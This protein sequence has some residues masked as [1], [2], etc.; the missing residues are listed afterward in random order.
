RA[1]NQQRCWSSG[2]RLAYIFWFA[3]ADPA[4]GWG[5]EVRTRPSHAGRVGR[6]SDHRTGDMELALGPAPLDEVA[7]SCSAGH[8]D[9]ARNTGWTDGL[10][11]PAVVDLNRPC[12]ARTK[13]LLPG[14]QH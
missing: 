5:S 6:S 3:V 12:D 9:R 10:V 2:S 8:G 11:F 1:G 4:H 13:L 14:C 7:G